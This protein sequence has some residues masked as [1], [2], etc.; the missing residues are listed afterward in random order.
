MA[1][2]AGGPLVLDTHIVLDVFVFKN[3]AYH[4]VGQALRERK[5]QWLATGHMMD[6]LLW[7]CERDYMAPWLARAQW[8][9]PLCVEQV[10]QWVQLQDEAPLC[11][12][13][14]KDSSDQ[15]FIDL[16][17][18]HQAVLISKDKAVLQLAKRLA[19]AGVAAG[20]TWSEAL[21][22]ITGTVVTPGNALH[23]A[24]PG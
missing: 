10:M 24:F 6:E 20:P 19:R 11:A 23:P 14:C 21:T 4:D 18:Q 15:C 9:P 13:R 17:V 5:A 3:P 22:R 7:V 2:A 16:A 1:E 8:T 12:L